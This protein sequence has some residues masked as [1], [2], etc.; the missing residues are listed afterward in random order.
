MDLCDDVWRWE[1]EEVDVDNAYKE[2][3]FDMVFDDS[4]CEASVFWPDRLL[5]QTTKRVMAA[6]SVLE[7]HKGE[8]FHDGAFDRRQ[9]RFLSKGAN[10]VVSASLIDFCEVERFFEMFRL[11]PYVVA[12]WECSKKFRLRNPYQVDYSDLNDCLENLRGFS[13]MVRETILSRS[14][15]SQFSNHRRASNKNFKS[16]NEYVKGLFCV[17]SRLLVVRVDLGYRKSFIEALESEREDRLTKLRNISDILKLHREKLFK[18]LQR[19]DELAMVGYI[20]KIEYGVEKGYHFH[21]MLF[22][23]GSCVRK[24]VVI[25]KRVCDYWDQVVTDGEG[26]SFNCNRNKRAYKHCCIGMIS[27][28]DVSAV[29][30]F[31]HAAVYLTKPDLFISVFFPDDRR[32]FGKGVLPKGGKKKSGRP[33]GSPELIDEG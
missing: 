13:K 19:L 12:F 18:R 9:R 3:M 16:F 7:T 11:C 14:F 23:N 26:V 6:V 2:K 29:K 5:Y 10:Q 32:N 22:F 4:E 25:A 24:D 8:I 21:V 30:G 1:I 20:W 17:Y 28:D 31:K 15:K 27:H 33:R